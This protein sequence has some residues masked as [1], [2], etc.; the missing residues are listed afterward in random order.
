VCVQQPVLERVTVVACTINVKSTATG[1]RKKRS[2]NA[3]FPEV[4]DVRSSGAR[5]PGDGNNMLVSSC[6]HTQ[7]PMMAVIISWSWFKLLML[8]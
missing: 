3:P 5:R 6:N 7:L 4:E 8:V 1:W 2:I